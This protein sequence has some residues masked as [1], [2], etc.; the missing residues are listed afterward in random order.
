MLLLKRKLPYLAVVICGLLIAISGSSQQLTFHNLNMQHG[1][2][3][4]NIHQ[5]CFDKDGF[6]WATSLNG[7]NMFDG[8]NVF[9]YNKQT[10]P[11]LAINQLGYL[12]CDSRNRIWVCSN[13]GL[14]MLDEERKVHRII[15]LENN[16]DL[17]IDYCFEVSNKGMIIT[18]KEK[19]YYLPHDEIT[20]I[21]I[22]WL[23]KILQG[24]V[25]TGINKLDDSRY[26]FQ[27]GNK[28]VLVDFLQQKILFEREIEN[29]ASVCFLNNYEILAVTKNF[30][31][32]NI[33]FHQ[34]KIIRHQT[35]LTDQFG[36][37]IR[38]QVRF[39]V[40][41]ADG[42]IYL[43]S[44]GDGIIRYNTE[45]NQLHIYQSDVK[46]PNSIRTNVIHLAASNNN[47]NLVFTSELGLQYTN[48][49]HNGFKRQLFG[50]IGHNE[51][52]F[53]SVK[54]IVMDNRHQLWLSAANKLLRT[55]S[56]GNTIVLNEKNINDPSKLLSTPLQMDIDD[57]G[58]I[59]VPFRNDGLYVYHPTG[60]LLKIFD[61]N[62]LPKP[63]Q[64]LR[65]ARSVNKDFIMAGTDNG[66]IT[67]NTS[68]FEID[69][70]TFKILESKIK[71]ERIVD[72]LSSGENIWIATSPRGSVWKYNTTTKTIKQ[73]T[74][75]DGLPSNRIYCFA[76]GPDQEILTGTYDGLAII[77][78]DK[79]VKTLTEK[80][81][82]INP[83]IDNIMVDNHGFAWI[84]NHNLLI[85][86]D[87]KKQTIQYFDERNGILNFSFNIGAGF[88]TNNQEFLLGTT[89]GIIRFHPSEITEK[90][91]TPKVI[92]NRLMENNLMQPL[93]PGNEI[94]L[95]HNNAR[96]NF[97]FANSELIAGSR[98]RYRYQL[99][100]VD[101][102]WSA[103]TKNTNVTYNLL[104]GTYAFRLQASYNSSDWFDSDH[105]AVITVKPPFYKT[106]WFLIMVGIILLLGGTLFHLYSRRRKLKSEGH[107]LV[108]YFT[109][110]ENQ[111]SSIEE[112]IW[113]MARNI[114]ARLGFED[115]VIYLVD[116]EKNMLIQKAAAG[117][118]S[119]NEN[120]LINLLTIPI[121][122]GVV[123]TAAATLK[124]VMVSDTSI[125]ERYIQDDANRLSELAVPIIYQNEIL[126]V[127]DSENSKRNFYT[128]DHVQILTTLAAIC[129]DKI[130]SLQA[131]DTLKI[132]EERLNDL[133][134]QMNETRLSA[135]R[136]QMNPHFLFNSLNAIQECIISEKYDSAYEYLS[137]FSKLLRLVLNHSEKNFISLNEELETIQLYLSLEELRFNHTF[138]YMINVEEDIDTNDVMVPSLLL[139]PFVENAIWHGLVNKEGEKKLKLSFRIKNEMI[140]CIIEDNGIGRKRSAW[141][142]EQKLGA[143]QFASRGTLL[144]EKRIQILNQQFSNMA[145]IET[146]DH[147]D[148]SHKSMGTSVVITLP[149]DIEN[150]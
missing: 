136:A 149:M 8:K 130:S 92:V 4:N 57:K 75:E 94:I 19:N 17:D 70:I 106:T 30:E 135:I 22:P 61:Q 44:Q 53:N 51:L 118:K 128:R 81:G 64:Q 148:P 110:L 80:N 103:P 33:N 49:F 72:I 139:Q 13:S 125:D 66:L 122:K 5:V 39:M 29:L 132:Q 114:I 85:K 97:H 78:N 146:I 140:Q 52:F 40:K 117:P 95:Q 133:K 45:K 31:L 83:R 115:C 46:K 76:L 35:N 99:E 96:I 18:S 73:F 36:N 59:W 25:I 16:P 54:S 124:P 6:V 111:Y 56:T 150:V 82:L 90:A 129:A 60:R 38:S 69:S 102:T 141:I 1:L 88:I 138:T 34:N 116:D 37:I 23:D 74:E 12:S 120:Q 79:V 65:S 113:D 121:G 142:K 77:K 145:Q 126:G 47:G 24:Q 42:K 10:Q 3:N 123:G 84:T 119:P 112:L 28:I 48:V 108:E 67:F 21:H 7:L 41:A 93:S 11:E 15:I 71:N 143:N 98:I 55:D 26:L 104:P 100:G 43:T 144:S 32:L 68:E 134:R 131:K 107:K 27:Q 9:H 105:N 14:S 20:S 109:L 137:R 127:I 63:V 87:I 147:Y 89:N 91:T 50:N 58:N 86:Y 2:A 101:D 62:E